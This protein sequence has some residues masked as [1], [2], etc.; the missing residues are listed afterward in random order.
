MNGVHDLGG[1]DG[2][3]P[4]PVPASDPFA[5]AFP[6][7]GSLLSPTTAYPQRTAVKSRTGA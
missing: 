1:T 4:V 2:L 5:P 7:R 3:G 6:G